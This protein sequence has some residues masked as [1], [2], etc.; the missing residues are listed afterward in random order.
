MTAWLIPL[1]AAIVGLVGLWM[2]RKSHKETI[3]QD[4]ELRNKQM[5]ED[6]RHHRQLL[7]FERKQRGRQLEVDRELRLHQID[8]ERRMREHAEARDTLAQV[9]Q[10]GT[11]VLE[12]LADIQVFVNDRSSLIGL[13]QGPDDTILEVVLRR[14]IELVTENQ[15]SAAVEELS[16]LNQTSD[17]QLLLRFGIEHRIVRKFR[18]FTASVALAT[19]EATSSNLKMI[20]DLE[21]PDRVLLSEIR[22]DMQQIESYRE[23]TSDA[24]RQWGEF[25]ATT[26]AWA[27]NPDQWDQAAQD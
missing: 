11:Q 16:S 24:A 1:L 9:L 3:D 2:N 15:P 21:V 27:R 22:A 4:R 17:A 6:R 14:Y 26:S 18:Q 7:R 5:D 23:A 25:L 10:H 8:S 19:E 12:L 20:R 13:V